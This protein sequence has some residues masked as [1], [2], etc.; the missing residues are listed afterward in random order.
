M[1]CPFCKGDTCEQL[2]RYVQQYDSR[3]V[4]VENVPA[5]VCSQCGEQLIK[6][7]VAEKIQQIVWGQAG[8]APRAM[9]VDSYD[10]ADV[11]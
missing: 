1:Q 4:V 10:F 2:I 8:S 5:D 6:A 11:A 9:E 3:V 7:D